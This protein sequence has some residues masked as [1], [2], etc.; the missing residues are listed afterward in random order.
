MQKEMAM[1]QQGLQLCYAGALADFVP[2]RIK[3]EQLVL[4]GPKWPGLAEIAG[5][6]YR[7]CPD[8]DSAKNVQGQWQGGLFPATEVM[9]EKPKSSLCY[10]EVLLFFNSQSA[11]TTYDVAKHVRLPKILTAKAA[12]KMAFKMSKYEKPTLLISKQSMSL[13]KPR[14]VPRKRVC[15]TPITPAKSYMEAIRAN[16][17]VDSSGARFL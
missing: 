6:Y 5:P 15:L 16:S 10:N 13:K 11:T 7:G 17:Q 14:F 9:P 1:Y 3:L 2:C 12:A 8:S 4:A